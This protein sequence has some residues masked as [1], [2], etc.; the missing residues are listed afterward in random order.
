MQISSKVLAVAIGIT[1]L[2]LPASAQSG[3]SSDQAYCAALSQKYVRYVGYG[4]ETSRHYQRSAPLA[5]QVA[6][7]QC[8]RGETAAAIPVLE[9]ELVNAGISLPGRG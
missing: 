7:T 5:G 6:V 2:P 1:A 8:Q 3:P 9:R 4:T